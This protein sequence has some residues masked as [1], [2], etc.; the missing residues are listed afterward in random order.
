M[1]IK[2][3]CQKVLHLLTGPIEKTLGA[4]QLTIEDEKFTISVGRAYS[5]IQSFSPSIIEKM[6]L[7]AIEP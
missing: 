2:G 1:C 5:I 3:L 6:A 7:G 4:F